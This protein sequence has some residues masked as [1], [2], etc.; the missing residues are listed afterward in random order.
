[1]KK[2]L[3]QL[4]WQHFEAHVQWYPY[5]R[6]ELW[7]YPRHLCSLSA[8]KYINIK[9]INIV[10]FFLNIVLDFQSATKCRQRKE[11]LQFCIKIKPTGCQPSLWCINKTKKHCLLDLYTSNTSFIVHEKLLNTRTFLITES[12]TSVASPTSIINWSVSQPA[13]HGLTHIINCWNRTKCINIG[14]V[15]W[16]EKS[17]K[18]TDLGVTGVCINITQYAIDSSSLNLMMAAAVYNWV[19]GILNSLITHV[20]MVGN[21]QCH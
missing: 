16:A 10:F 1:M 21:N 15:D 6:Y 19:S 20:W 18:H 9:Q 14:V 2:W 13:Q 11:N 4:A 17:N 8:Y 5:P 7:R 12:I 3:P